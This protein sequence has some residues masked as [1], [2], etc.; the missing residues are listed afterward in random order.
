MDVDQ[1]FANFFL[2]LFPSSWRLPWSII[3]MAGSRFFSSIQSIC[4]G[5]NDNLEKNWVAEQHNRQTA[6]KAIWISFFNNKLQKWSFPFSSFTWSCNSDSCDFFY[7]RGWF[8]IDL[9]AA[10]P[11]DLL[12]FGSDTDEVAI[13][14]KF[15]ITKTRNMDFWLSDS[16]TYNHSSNIL[17]LNLILSFLRVTRRWDVLQKILTDTNPIYVW[18]SY[19]KYIIKYII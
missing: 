7:N 6:Q 15:T 16:L 4:S 11:F 8:I 14:I 3:Q 1:F 5:K 13:N 10:I 18:K 17:F 12:L 9:V 2:S 19:I